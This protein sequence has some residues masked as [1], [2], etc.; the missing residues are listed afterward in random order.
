MI[1]SL[2][3]SCSSSYQQKNTYIYFSIDLT[4]M[5]AQLLLNFL[6][7]ANC[8]EAEFWNGLSNTIQ[9]SLESRFLENHKAPWGLGML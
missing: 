1:I 2:C 4:I 3:V 6:A 8:I 5:S 9:S 7:L